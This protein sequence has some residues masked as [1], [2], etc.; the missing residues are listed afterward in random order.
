MQRMRET[1]TSKLAKKK[2]L[3]NVEN[4]TLI[5]KIFTCKNCVREKVGVKFNSENSFNIAFRT[6]YLTVTTSESVGR[7]LRN[8]SIQCFPRFRVL[9]FPAVRD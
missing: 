2:F 9:Q 3:T 8:Y 6:S 7:F 5:G 4:F 1:I